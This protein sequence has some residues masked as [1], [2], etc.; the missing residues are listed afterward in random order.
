MGQK[1]TFLSLF[2]GCGG[3]DLGFLQAGYQCLSAFDISP[4]A[5]ENY[6]CNIGPDAHICNLV[7][8][9]NHYP[10]PDVDVVIAGPPCQGFSVAGK[11]RLLD[12]RN[13]LLLVACNIAIEHNPR[14]F[15]VEN[16]RGVV[17]GKHKVY[18]DSMKYVLQDAGYKILEYCCDGTEFGLAQT[19]KRMILVA[20]RHPGEIQFEP[21]KTEKKV[22]KDVL[23]SLDSAP[24]HSKKMFPENSKIGII[25]K[26]ISQGQKLCN[27]RGGDRSIHTWNIPE[28][29]GETG[30]DEKKL[31]E[32]MMHIR[33]RRR[34][35]DSGDA[36][37][38]PLSAL[39]EV[40]GNKAAII[41]NSLIRKGYV[42]KKGK[43]YDLTN[44]FNGKYRRLSWDE[45]SLTVDTRFGNPRYF[46]HPTEDRGFTVRE[47]ARIQ[48]FPD[49]YV[50][51]GDEASQ[52]RLVGNAVP[53][54]IAKHLAE[55]IKPIL[56]K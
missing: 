10:L 36:D 24:N 41:V 11:R 46:L 3:F 50:F 26:N 12:P 38:V 52:Y 32:S 20:Y 27:V 37:P 43:D 21:P 51:E 56:Q 22:L 2:C 54:P 14:I 28:V 55:I 42:R 47:A 16:V 29:F 9:F 53:P 7:K 30:N 5:I 8:G 45:P 13:E 35:R 1:Y 17:A 4:I 40:I 34:I 19:R 33:R 44:T 48:G 49:S 25:A 6:K 18:W 39:E 15:I 31:L 23:T